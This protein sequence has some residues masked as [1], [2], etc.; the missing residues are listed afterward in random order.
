MR[1]KS[2]SSINQCQSPDYYG[3]GV[4]QTINDIN[5]AHGGEIKVETRIDEENPDTFRKGE[6]LYA[7]W[8]GTKFIIILPKS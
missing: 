3:A 8:H 2:V 6:G 4:I 7:E 5:E 1:V